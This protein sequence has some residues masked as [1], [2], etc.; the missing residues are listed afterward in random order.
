MPYRHLSGW[1]LK[2]D[3]QATLA[4][5]IGGPVLENG[6]VHG[7]P[8]IPRYLWPAAAAVREPGITN[9]AHCTHCAVHLSEV[10]IICLKSELPHRSI[11]RD[12]CYN[13]C[14]QR[15]IVRRC[16]LPPCLRRK[17]RKVT[18]DKGAG[19]AAKVPGDLRDSLPL[20]RVAD[21]HREIF[22]CGGIGFRRQRASD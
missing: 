17:L 19:I 22:E 10:L 21:I 2:K 13:R 7:D 4:C 15:F 5:P 16:R 8:V 11:G 12:R 3:D 18:L 1:H 9:G 20:E 6:H 14:T